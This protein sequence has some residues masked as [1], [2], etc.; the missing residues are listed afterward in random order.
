M[1]AGASVINGHMEIA[2]NVTITGMSMV[3]RPI[4]EAGVYSSGM[5]AQNNRAWRKQAA[6]LMK[7]DDMH[8]RISKLEKSLKD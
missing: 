8:K 6:R 7:I 2:D 1:I 4:T 3:M 5:P